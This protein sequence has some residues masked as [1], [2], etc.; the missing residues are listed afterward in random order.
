MLGALSGRDVAVALHRRFGPAKKRRARMAKHERK[1]GD[2]SY[3]YTIALFGDSMMVEQFSAWCFLLHGAACE[4][5]SRQGK[6]HNLRWMNVERTYT[7]SAAESEAA[8][9][10]KNEKGPEESDS[11][12]AAMAKSAESVRVTLRVRFARSYTTKGGHSVIAAVGTIARQLLSVDPDVVAGNLASLHWQQNMRSQEQWEGNLRA[13]GDTLRRHLARRV[14]KSSTDG[15]AEEGP[16]ERLFYY[17]GNTMI[18]MGRTQG[19]NSGRTAAF[20]EAA[21]RILQQQEPLAEAA[22]GGGA[23]AS[24]PSP[25]FVTYFDPLHLSVA[26]RESS[27]DGQH[28]ACYHRYGG[29]S[30]TITQ[31]WM[32]HL[33]GALR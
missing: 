19:L 30:A 21:R 5:S 25:P 23:I 16:E 13:F 33:I 14:K 20:N 18:Q 24:S 2:E 8:L 17:W 3:T 11:S 1:E 7:L 22:G 32:A 28:W 26:R 31:L 27:F 29:V 15:A 10:G 6:S 9:R 4:R 12:A